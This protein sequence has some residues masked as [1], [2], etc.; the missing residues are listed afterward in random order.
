[1]THL[2][3]S[4]TAVTI[5]ALLSACSGEDITAQPVEEAPLKPQPTEQILVKT[6]EATISALKESLIITD[7]QGQQSLASVEVFKGIQFATSERF[8]HSETAP[9][10]GEIDARQFTD[11][12][13]QLKITQQ[14]QSED[15]LNLNIWR[16]SGTQEMDNL[17]VY[18]VIHGGDFEYGSGADP[19]IQGD[20]VVAQGDKD[21]KAFISI[22]F[23]YRLG[24]LGS[25]WKKGTNVNGNY[26]IGDQKS[27]LQWVN[28]N[29]ADFGGDPDNVTVIGQG[30]GAMSSGLLQQEVAN[31]TMD[32]NY[33]QRNIM[34][35][36]AY[37]F[38]YRSYAVAKQQVQDLSLQDS[39]LQDVLAAQANILNPVSRV[40]NWLLKSTLP[41]L[42]DLSPISLGKADKTP[43][44]MLMPFSPYLECKKTSF[45]GACSENAAQPADVDFVV[46]T[47]I[48]VNKNEA[49]TLAMLPSL[50]FLIPKILELVN[51]SQPELAYKLDSE[52]QL[53][54]MFEWLQHD[55]NQTL[56]NQQLATF[57]QQDQATA[58]L[59][60]EDILSRLPSSAYQAIT[61]L[62]FGLANTET[63]TQLLNLADYAP[64]D[65]RDLS[66]ALG[67]M[68]RFKMIINDML[69]AGPARLKAA[70]ADY[71]GMPV[72]FYHFDF[73]PSF[74]V[75]TYD[76]SS[77]D[78]NTY[79]DEFFN[80]ISC[81]SGACNGSELPFVFNKKIKRDG[82]EVHPT[83]KEITLMNKLSRLWFSDALFDNYQ[84]SASEDTVMVINQQ[85]EIKLEADWDYKHQ[86]G[87]DP[88]LYNGRLNG[89]QNEGLLLNYMVE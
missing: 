87:D 1:M 33:F 84:Y 69:F 7:T 31:N 79:F 25:Y 6:S 3:R 42:N 74:N 71:A 85:G 68:K 28:E 32:N 65:E 50:T 29:I 86:C 66:H 26:G 57:L 12:C 36:N 22:S 81:I 70:Q 89:L 64:L 62:Y 9:L 18:V 61:Q 44:A 20:T 38:E 43:M 13:P 48:G 76:N 39:P 10:M 17:P 34:Q 80:T 27:A 46:P 83:T 59:A 45:L 77:D 78:I 55:A 52:T 16:P 58:Q 47:V 30:A 63:T 51:E 75:W 67:N 72:T 23:N 54:A 40:T 11:A 60:L 35:S 56:L 14:T 49:N 8:E 82:T 37:G 41:A 24:L 21:N 15:C 2:S 19:L 5:S 4:I 73:K 53:I 88:A